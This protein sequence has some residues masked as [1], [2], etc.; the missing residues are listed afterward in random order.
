[1]KYIRESD[2]M[3]KQDQE[4]NRQEANGAVLED[5]P[6]TPD[7]VVSERPGTIPALTPLLLT[8]AQA[9][10]LLSLS[11]RKVWELAAC[12]AIPCIKIGAV[13]RY[14][15]IDLEVWVKRGC[16]TGRSK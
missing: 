8:E 7:N 3:R 1:M 10:E 13:K 14:R 12:G 6:A 16:P 2:A 5:R 11:A 15:L 4:L 9:G